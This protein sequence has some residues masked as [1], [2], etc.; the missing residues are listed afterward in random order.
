MSEKILQDKVAVITGA[1]KGLG[2][3]MA[4]GMANAGASI[5][6]S[7][8]K[9]DDCEKV[10]AEIESNGG[11][12]IAVACHVGRWDNCD[13]LIDRAV[14]E[15]GRI[16]ILVNNAGIAPVA[17]TMADITE[18]L[19]DKTIAVNLKGPVRLTAAAAPYMPAGSA[20]INISSKASIRGT[21]LTAIY[22]AAKSGLNVWTQVA[23]QE[24]GPRGIRVNCIVCGTFHTDSFDKSIPTAD[25]E[26]A[27]ISRIPLGRIATPDEI[28]GTALFLASD[29]SS[30]MSGALLAL[31]GG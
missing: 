26:A 12:A 13:T 11:H 17:P 22:A 27:L 7:S 9:V 5:V 6:V 2:R 21:P 20:I 1:S 18:D 3:A 28:V 25:I 19:F 4:L 30:Y 15:F 23:S 24:L 29:A 8:R 31:D 10:V 14:K 16:D